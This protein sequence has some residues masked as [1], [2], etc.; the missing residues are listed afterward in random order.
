MTYQDLILDLMMLSEEQRQLDVLIFDKKNYS[1]IKSLSFALKD[2]NDKAPLL[3]SE[4]VEEMNEV[5]EQLK[6]YPVLLP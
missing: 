3:N 1:K 4:Y 2:K 6:E 5:C